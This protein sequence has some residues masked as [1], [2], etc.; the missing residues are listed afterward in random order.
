M[1]SREDRP[2]QPE[3]GGRRWRRQPEARPHQILEAAR[4]TFTSKGYFGAT[5]DDVA[6]EA[7][8]TKGTIYLYYPSKQVLFSEMVRA[9]ADEA[10]GSLRAE[11]AAGRPVPGHELIRRLVTQCRRL[12]RRPDYQAMLR[13]IIGEAGR[14]PE[15]AEAFYRE[16][17]LKRTQ[18]LAAFFET[19]M[20]RGEIRRLDPL[21]VARAV[22]AMVWGFVLAQETMR[23]EAVTPWPEAV[24]VDTFTTMLWKG[25][26]R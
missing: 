13:L 23:G 2:S 20:D 3:D 8:I 19:A 12:F 11:V 15:E 14:F 22:V 10:F 6:R 25:L 4:R 16:V 9:Y 26:E 24:V 1:S 21:L 5:L 17:V 18:E 7:G